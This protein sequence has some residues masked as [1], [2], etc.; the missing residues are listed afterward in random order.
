MK[1]DRVYTAGLTNRYD[2]LEFEL[3]SSQIKNNDG[4]SVFDMCEVE[5]PSGWSQMATNVM[6]Q[7]YLRKAGVPERV[8]RVSESELSNAKPALDSP[9]GEETSSKQAFDRIAG[10]WAHWGLSLRYFDDESEALAF[11][12][13]MARMMAEQIGAPNSP[14]WFNTGLHWAYGITGPAQGHYY[15]NEADPRAWGEGR[16]TW[17]TVPERSTNCY[18]RPQPH[19]CFIQSVDDDLVNEGG[20]MDLWMREAR[21]FK[22]GSGT[23]ANFSKIRG[24]GEPLSGGGQSSG[25]MSFLAVGDRAAGAIKS[26]GTTRRAAKM[27]T[28]DID[29][30]D[31]EEF[32]TWK[33][34]EEKKVAAMVAGAKVC[35]Y[36]MNI[37]YETTTKYGRASK[38]VKKEM[39]K[40]VKA[41]VPSN[42]A[43]RAAELAEANRPLDFPDLDTDWQGEAYATVG[44]QN[45]NNSIR[46]SDEFMECLKTNCHWK[47]TRRTDGSVHKTVPSKK[48]WDD[49]VES[50]WWCAD[51]GL[52]FDSTINAW[53]TCPEGGRINGS[54]PCSE[55]MFLD[56]TA[57]N[58]ASLNLVKFLNSNGT[59]NIAKFVHACRLWTIALE[60]SVAMAQFPSAKIALLSHKYRTLGLGFANL[61][62]ALMRMGLPYDSDEGRAFCAEITSLLTGVAYQ[63]SAEMA[64]E[65]GP[66]PEYATNKKH[67]ARVIDMHHMA[68]RGTKPMDRCFLANE[69]HRFDSIRIRALEAWKVA[70]HA[71]D[72]GA[73]LRNAQVSC[74]APTGTIGLVMDC[75]TT[76]IE[77]DYALVKHKSLAGG[78]S[79]TIINQSVPAA[80][81]TLD[82]GPRHIDRI[83][84]HTLGHD[85]LSTFEIDGISIDELVDADWDAVDT[86]VKKDYSLFIQLPIV[87][88]DVWDTLKDY[89][90]VDEA[91]AY[92][93]GHGSVE[94]APGLKSEHL[95][96]FD[97][98][99]RCGNGTRLIAPMGHVKMMAVAQ[100]FISGAISKTI[101]MDASATFD[102]VNHVYVESWNLGLKAIAMYRDGSK[103]SQPLTLILDDDNDD[104]LAE[105]VDLPLPRQIEQVAAIGARHVLPSKRSGYTQ[106]MI[107]GGHK[108]YLRTGEYPDGN[109]GEVFIDM[110]REGSAFRSIM[111]AFCIAVSMGLQHGVSLDSFVDKFTF[112]R[113]EPSGMVEGHDR[114]K[115]AMSIIDAVF[116][117]LGINYAGRNE[118]AHV[119]PMEE[120]NRPDAVRMVVNDLS[121]I[122]RSKG[123]EG[124]ACPECQ[125]MRMVR[126]GTCLRCTSCG[127]TTGCS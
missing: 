93:N 89:D 30:P 43:S 45:S 75:D 17:V 117:D 55:Y 87:F 41:G 64:A 86:L 78:G 94:G 7:K 72:Y 114:I 65:L 83:V 6:A 95:A 98:A 106:R 115:M 105:I 109:L 97:C 107:V 26:G 67:V 51:P 27:V 18:E 46:V 99:S 81:I 66:F 36:R 92:V 103:L 126:S 2:G 31:V 50:A 116:R 125:E 42:Y 3:R 84:R 91:N 73:G 15:V 35:R 24:R 82:Y 71:V 57:C 53:H 70:E 12:D 49:I 119:D 101:N 37:I 76:G 29:H 108:L 32:A 60:I 21:L 20:I 8:E 69:F 88:P 104:E 59:F 61:G 62:A 79:F 9:M 120:A 48:L 96:V 23:G 39:R 54:N 122:A 58:L 77:P 34:R 85:I 5:V 127:S 112:M 13:E 102:D 25:L 11:R 56:D 80:L 4:T 14:Q 28:L 10:C 44:G 63:T 33:V 16:D 68:A 100:P 22:Y 121:D 1:V 123:F 124:E 90:A 40:A 19:A 111:N 118:L 110:H 38:Q 47:L 113:F 52:Q 74:I